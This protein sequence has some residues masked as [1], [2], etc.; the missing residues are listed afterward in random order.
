MKKVLLV[1]F[2]FIAFTMAACDSTA[3]NQATQ[4]STNLDTVVVPTADSVKAG[5]AQV[6]NVSVSH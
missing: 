4:D 5:S 1:L 2:V 6:D 3:S